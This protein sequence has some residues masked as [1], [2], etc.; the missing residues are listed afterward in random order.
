VLLL[1]ERLKRKRRKTMPLFKDLV[2]SFRYTNHI[3]PVFLLRLYVAYYF[4]SDSLYRQSVGYLEKPLLSAQ[5]D[6]NLLRLDQAPFFIKSFYLNLIQENWL[7]WSK[8]LI[9]FE[10]V[11]GLC[12]LF[13]L[14][15][16]P[17]G[18]LSIIHIYLISFIASQ[19]EISG[20]HQITVMLALLIMFGAGR[21]GGLDY[22]FYKRQR[23]LI[24]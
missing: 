11:V 7:F 3:W 14:L 22:F 20:L 16:R 4:I 8:L 5:I 10:W 15:V 6:Q 1:F 21:V 18:I 9:S 24:W 17:V 13:G 23:G 12:L 19:N 2:E